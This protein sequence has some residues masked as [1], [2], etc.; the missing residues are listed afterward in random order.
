MIARGPGVRPT[1]HPTPHRDRAPVAAIAAAGAIAWAPN[2]LRPASP[3]EAGFLIVGS[4]WHHGSSLYGDY[5]VD[6]PPLLIAVHQVAAALGGLLPLRVVGLVAVVAT[7]LLAGVVGSEVARATGGRRPAVVRLVAAGFAAATIASPALGS[8]ATTGEVLT[9]PLVVG[10]TAA[11]LRAAREDPA[12]ARGWWALAGASAAAAPLIKQNA[13]EG[14]LAVGLIALTGPA[15]TTARLRAVA[16]AAGAALT[17]VAGVVLAAATRGTSPRGLLE[18]VV[19]FRADASA[20]IAQDRPAA[21]DVR[22]HEL[23]HSLLVSGLPLVLAVAAAACLWR[24]SRPSRP[25]RPWRSG[26]PREG[27]SPAPAVRAVAAAMV[28]WEAVAIAAGGSYWLHYL[29]NLVPGGVLLVSAAAARSRRPGVV[30][31]PVVLVG[32]LTAVAALGAATHLADAAHR[33]PPAVARYLASHA[34]PGD[35]ATVA[36]G[37]ADILLDAGLRS[38]YANLWSLPVR[39]RDPHLRGLVDVLDSSRAPTWVVVHGRTLDGWGI[40]RGAAARADA[41]LAHRYACVTTAS[42]DTVWRLRD[43]RFSQAMPSLSR[44]RPRL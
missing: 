43:Q 26:A 10:A 19:L 1:R 31:L 36:Y 44:S 7:V 27:R 11:A 22:V 42:G 8:V 3:D 21:N 13:I 17:T 33:R 29:L 5:W 25:R 14:V 12:R 39:V 18:A 24:P 23:L 40:D 2:L 35:T 30:A 20:V 34:R 28:A 15:P 32:A 16:V 4:Q 37:K 38:P 41:L 6:R 9:A